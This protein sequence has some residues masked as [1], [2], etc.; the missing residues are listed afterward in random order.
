MYDA[1]CMGC[2]CQSEN[3]RNDK[4]NKDHKDFREDVEPLLGVLVVRVAFA[5][6][7]AV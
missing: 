3:D 4:Y 7:V 1:F 6:P 5:V 2:L